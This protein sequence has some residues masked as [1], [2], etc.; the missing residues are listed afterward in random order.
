M[1]LD[2]YLIADSPPTSPKSGSGIFMRRDGATIEMSREEWDRAFPDQE[3]VVMSADGE[4]D[5]TVY[6]RNITHNLTKMADAAGIYKHLW[7]P[8]EIGITKAKDLIAP[9]A[10]G[11]LLL[12]AEP[13]RFKGYNPSNGWGD[14]G[15][16]VAFVADYLQACKDYP[17]ASV[18]VSR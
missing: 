13:D 16:L 15:G 11:L 6:D 2:V 3:P 17:E 9:L 8:D 14:Y 18:R 4:A 7:R 5:S 12:K 1:S 10:A